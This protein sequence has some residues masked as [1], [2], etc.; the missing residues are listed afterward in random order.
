MINTR[1]LCSIL[2]V[3]TLALAGILTGCGNGDTSGDTPPDEKGVTLKI[4]SQGYAEV[5]ILAELTK[6]LIEDRTPHKVEHIRNLGSSMAA[7]EATVS[8]QLDMCN[9]F[10][11][12]LF[13]GLYEQGL[14]EEYR[15]PQKVW[16]FVHENLPKDHGLT[17]F[18]SYG[19]NN[20]FCVAVPRKWADENNINK[21]SDLAPFAK[22]MSL[23]VTP[24]WLNYPGQGYKEYTEIYGFS[25]KETV[26]MNRSLMYMAIRN[27]EVDAINTYSTDGELVVENLK[28][29]EDDKGFNPPYYGILMV[30]TEVLEEHPELEEALQG[31]ENLI[32]T[33]QMQELNKKVSVDEMEPEDV[34]REHLKA[35]GL[36][37]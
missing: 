33:E 21:Q 11:G 5:E 22:E 25:F 34:A 29:L 28:I 31:I 26:E 19:Y 24:S 16:E 35:N 17:V 36:I 30:R 23:A 4:G 2:L 13:L 18:P 3:L 12:T 32:T 1:R 37:D 10:T 6:I 14:T 7:H 15:D 9:N 8:G 20:T 27:D